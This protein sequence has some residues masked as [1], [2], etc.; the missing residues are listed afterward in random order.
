MTSREE[1]FQAIQSREYSVV[2]T[3]AKGCSGMRDNYGNTGLMCAVLENDPHMV[4]LLASHEAGM[5]SATGRTALYM[6]VAAGHAELCY[7]LASRERHILTE[8]NRTMLMVA[9][10]MGNIDTVVVLLPYF[11][12]ERDVAGFSAL[13]LAVLTQDTDLL[14]GCAEPQ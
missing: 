6:A 1:W 14:T 9:V 2:A 10:E 8:Q 4:Q 3:Y 7:I 12:N 5:V 13:D 11:G